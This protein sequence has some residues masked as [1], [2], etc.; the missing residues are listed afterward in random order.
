MGHRKSEASAVAPRA[1][2]RET[3]CACNTAEACVSCQFCL[4][5]HCVCAAT[6]VGVPPRRLREVCRE[7]RACDCRLPGDGAS[8]CELCLGCRQQ[9]ADALS[10]CRCRQ[11]QELARQRRWRR[12]SAVGGTDD[13]ACLCFSLALEKDPIDGQDAERAKSY[14]QHRRRR[15]MKIKRNAGLLSV[16]S[17][18]DRKVRTQAPRDQ[19]NPSDDVDDDEDDDDDDDDQQLHPEAEEVLSVLHRSVVHGFRRPYLEHGFSTS[20]RWQ[21]AT[22]HLESIEPNPFTELNDEN[23]NGPTGRFMMS[24]DV[25]TRTLENAAYT[26][27][28]NETMPSEELVDFLMFAASVKANHLPELLGT[29]DDSAAVAIGVV[30]E[31]YVRQLV[32]DHVVR[33]R[34]AVDAMAKMSDDS[35]LLTEYPA[36]LW[37]TATAPSAQLFACTALEGF[38]WSVVHQLSATTSE[39]AV[40]ET[41]TKRLAKDYLSVPGLGRTE[42]V[43]SMV[44]VARPHHVARVEM[45][46]REIV[47]REHAASL[48]ALQTTSRTAKKRKRSLPGDTSALKISAH[49]SGITGEAVYRYE[50][51]RDVAKQYRATI[52]A[53]GFVSREDAEQ[54]IAK[55]SRTLA[56]E[57]E[58]IPRQIRQAIEAAQRAEEERRKGELGLDNPVVSELYEQLRRQVQE[59]KA[60]RPDGNTIFDPSDPIVSELYDQLRGQVKAYKA[61]QSGELVDNHEDEG[62]DDP[63]EAIMSELYEQLRQQ[64]SE[65][66]ATHKRPKR[67]RRW[68]LPQGAEPSVREPEEIANANVGSETDGDVIDVDVDSESDVEIESDSEVDSETD[69]ASDQAEDE[70]EGEGEGDT[71]DDEQSVSEADEEDDAQAVDSG[72]DIEEADTMTETEEE[73]SAEGA[74]RD[75]AG[76]ILRHNSVDMNKYEVL[77][78][79]GEGA[80]GVVLKCRNRETSEVVAIKKF[81]ENEDDD[82]MVRK[83]TLR[84]VK[85]LRL[86]KHPNIVAL[87]EAFRRKGRLYL[88]FE[89]VEKNLLEVLEEKPNGIDAELVRQYVFQLCC[90]IHHCHTNGVIHRDIKPEN[91]LVNVSNGDHSLRLCDF[92]FARSLGSAG[93]MAHELTEYVAT[94][95]Y[96]APELLLGDTKYTKSVDIWAIGC[97]MG[98]LVEGQPVFPGESEIDQ[99]YVIQKTLG[100]LSK[101]HMEL[102]ATNPRFSGMKMPDVKHPETLQRKYCGR[103]SKRGLQFLEMALQLN[104]EERLTSEDCLRHPYFDGLNGS[105]AAAPS[106]PAEVKPLPL[107]FLGDK[108]EEASEN[109]MAADHAVESSLKGGERS[110]RLPHKAEEKHSGTAVKD[111]S[112]RK[113]GRKSRAHRKSQPQLESYGHDDLQLAKDEDETLATGRRKERKRQQLPRAPT[114]SRKKMEASPQPSGML[115]MMRPVSRQSLSQGVQVAAST[116]LRYLPHLSASGAADIGFVVGSTAAGL[117]QGGCV[118]GGRKDEDLYNY[119]VY[120]QP[121]P[122]PQLSKKAPKKCRDRGFVDPYEEMDC[123]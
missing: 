97:I 56:A 116:G 13:S 69:S 102:F 62:N 25:L 23:D 4:E 19:R 113:T 92:G 61:R 95:W 9:S 5:R 80:Y 83:T 77:G 35:S 11:H 101:R 63:N 33:P 16:D 6:D 119:P 87:K 66:K 74:E 60:S 12:G 76:C 8:R 45:W 41:L 86:L 38:D 53:D 42:S 52:A 31:E 107:A 110:F 85:M 75:D 104:A 68:I 32:Q 21:H 71:E 24:E 59:Y 2:R 122:Q 112:S 30:I 58:R 115:G 72:V 48:A 50:L 44:P 39:D 106:V 91:L 54:A 43:V 120:P 28:R 109:E 81:K 111:K 18:F 3:R 26:Q 7:S 34:A 78:V 100:P 47:K 123:S 103:L 94:R 36:A 93:G 17:L 88:V 1:A 82:P 117:H 49:A 98:E 27:D 65:Y 29:F 99:L 37:G 89:Y 22:T 79:I 46:T 118:D 14:R 90:A 67:R 20:T 73:R 105:S 10:H 114:G 40:I 57:N 64:V 84:E 55:L 51:A 70:G 96:R 121:H 15:I 108:E